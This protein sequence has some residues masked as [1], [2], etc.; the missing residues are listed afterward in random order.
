MKKLSHTHGRTA[1]F[2]LAAMA[3]LLAAGCSGSGEGSVTVAG[4]VPLAYAMRSTAMT[5]NP[6]N[7]SPSAPGGDLIIREK[8]SPSA[9]EHNITSRF[10]RD[11]AGEI[12]RAHV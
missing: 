12:G 11:A 10:T 1:T 6:T 5:M 7:G 8:S 3:V 9:P 4:D 2:G